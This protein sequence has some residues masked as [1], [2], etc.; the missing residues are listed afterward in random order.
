M[1]VDSLSIVGWH[2]TITFE[3]AG[4]G[5]NQLTFNPDRTGGSGALCGRR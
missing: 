2:K 5:K 3:R 1:M 4:K